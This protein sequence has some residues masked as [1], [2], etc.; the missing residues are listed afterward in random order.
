MALAA[1]IYRGLRPQSD[2]DFSMP[3]ESVNGIDGQMPWLK[4]KPD[5]R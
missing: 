4:E 1:A 2:T 5:H 3:T